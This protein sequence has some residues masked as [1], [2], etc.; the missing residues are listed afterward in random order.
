M[1]HRC[2]HRVRSYELDGNNHVNNAV[3]LNYFEYA[4]MEF[5]KDIGF[6]YRNF[7]EKGYSLFVTEIHVKY[8]QAATVLDELV[9][10][11]RPIKKRRASGVFR[12]VISRDGEELCSADITWA[13]INSCGK[14]EALPGEFDLKALYPEV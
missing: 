9:I 11:T 7:R 14:P 5:L 1:T 10:T 13:C 6:D 12:Q 8:H 3:Y 4:R 2:A